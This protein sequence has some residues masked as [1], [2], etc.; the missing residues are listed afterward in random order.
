MYE[1]VRAKTT[2]AKPL[3]LRQ[4][5]RA[6]R[7]RSGNAH[8]PRNVHETA[9]A[10]RV[11]QASVPGSESDFDFDFDWRCRALAALPVCRGGDGPAVPPVGVRAVAADRTRRLVMDVG[12]HKWRTALT[13]R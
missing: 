11:A 7:G 3:P 4:S 8:W 6:V 1:S 5:T 2:C 12:L 10:L 9:W 13:A